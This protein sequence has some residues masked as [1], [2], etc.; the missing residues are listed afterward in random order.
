MN[1]KEYCMKTFLFSLV[2]LFSGLVFAGPEE[3]LAAQSCYVVVKEAGVQIPESV[4]HD[5]CLEN[6]NINLENESIIVY[7]YFHAKLYN[8]LTV[9]QVGQLT[10]GYFEFKATNS[11]FSFSETTCGAGEFV[12]LVI[13]GQ[14]NQLGEASVD[15]LNF[16][17]N[18]E[19]TNDTCHSHPQV[20]SFKFQLQ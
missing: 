18:H 19:V 1:T 4:P 11:L 12:E 17:V 14:V 10:E 15:K 13:T 20:Q 2:V 7:S 6:L 16:Q 5:F 8:G 9:N 3:H